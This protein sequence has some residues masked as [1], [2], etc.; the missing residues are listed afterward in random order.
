M[1]IMRLAHYARQARLEDV[2]TPTLRHSFTHD[3]VDAGVSLDRVAMLLG[4]ES[5]DT[6]ARYTRARGA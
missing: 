2:T 4:H 5:L 6:T 1:V 3:L